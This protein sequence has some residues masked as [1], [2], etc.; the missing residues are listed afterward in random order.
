[1]S[2]RK[3]IKASPVQLI[4]INTVTHKFFSNEDGVFKH[5]VFSWVKFE[6][7]EL[8]S[9]ILKLCNFQRVRF[10]SE[11]CGTTFEQCN[12]EGYIG[13]AVFRNCTFQNVEIK[14]VDVR[15]IKFIDCKAR[16]TVLVDESTN[17]E[18]KLI[19]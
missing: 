12:I 5:I 4:G 14:A 9:K 8:D 3:T 7:E 13:N 6:A 2:S 10:L 1:M 16:G 15:G 17:V 18:T 11:I 19:I